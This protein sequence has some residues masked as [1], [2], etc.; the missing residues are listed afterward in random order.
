VLWGYVHR[1]EAL[2]ERLNGMYAFAIS[3]ARER[4]LVMIRD[5]MGVKPLY[6]YPTADGVLFGSEP[7]A[8][9]VNPLAQRT[10]DVRGYASCPS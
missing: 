9:L 7:K 10:V 3:D 5:R 2:A 6:F 1:G 8:I 4:K